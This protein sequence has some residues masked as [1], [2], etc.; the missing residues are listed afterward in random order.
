MA[1]AMSSGREKDKDASGSS[2]KSEVDKSSRRD[3]HNSRDRSTQK[4]RLRMDELDGN[5]RTPKPR[6]PERHRPDSGMH[7]DK[8]SFLNL[9]NKLMTTKNQSHI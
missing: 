5:K 9:R 2:R 6:S 7:N 1:L 3:R 8:K 4:G